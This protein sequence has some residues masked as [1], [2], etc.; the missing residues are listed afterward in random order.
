MFAQNPD[1][2]SRSGPQSSAI[3]EYTN[4]INKSGPQSKEAREFRECHKGDPQ[5]TRRAATLDR[6][7]E[8]KKLSGI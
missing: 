6:L 3:I 5:F 2:G 4:I 7:F 8:L 1:N